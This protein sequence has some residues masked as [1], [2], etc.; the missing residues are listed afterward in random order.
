[1]IAARLRQ[2]ERLR[3]TPAAC[4]AQLRPAE[5]R[6][7]CGLDGAARRA[8]AD[9]HDR[10]G[11]TMRGHDRAMRV[12]RTLADLDGSDTVQRAHVA[13]AV[14]YRAPGRDRAAFEREAA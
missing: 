14:A 12:A 2:R 8:L 3:G 13:Q 1:V 6:R 9:A 10:A 5:L 7:L 11:L 4:N